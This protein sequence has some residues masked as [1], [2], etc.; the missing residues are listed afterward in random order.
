MNLTPDKNNA[1]WRWSLTATCVL[2]LLTSFRNLDNQLVA[3]LNANLVSVPTLLGNEPQDDLKKMQAVFTSLDSKVIAI[4]E[5]SH[6]TSEFFEVRKKLIK[7]FSLDPQFAK[8]G[9]EAPMAEVEDLNSYLLEDRGDLKSILKSFRLY[10]YECAEFVDL[11]SQ[12]KEINKNRKNKISFFGFDIQ[13]PFKSLEKIREFAKEDES[14]PVESISKLLSDYTLLNNQVYSHNFSRE[15]FDSLKYISQP[16]LSDVFTSTKNGL[17]IRDYQTN[18]RQFLL[19]NDPSVTNYEMS[20]MSELRDSLMAVNVLNQVTNNSKMIILAHNAHVQK[21][22]SVYS[23]SMGYF[24]KRNLKNDY[25]VIGQTTSSGTVT[26]F[27]P[28]IGKISADNLLTSPDQTSFEYYFSLTRKPVFLIQTARIAG[29]I[30]PGARPKKYR[31]LPFGIP[32]DQYVTGDA[33]EDFDYIIHIEKTSGNKS[34]YL[35]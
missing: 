27:K 35:N 9:L 25:K 15:D 13:S 14:I 5:Q 28:S 29:L 11:V 23:K 31:L 6:G 26:A 1:K 2:L 7:L 3:I 24:L 20:I 8:I 30:K 12:V 21:T 16:V 22:T 17:S 32:N 18:Y 19:L 33:I 34:F 4:G 10:N